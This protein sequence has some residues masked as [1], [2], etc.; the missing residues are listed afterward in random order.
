MPMS[1]PVHRA[2]GMRTA[3]QRRKE[4]DAKRGTV[5][6]R[7][8]GNQW[9]EASKAYR[10]LHPQCECTE[11]LKLP[12]IRRPP[13]EVVDHRIPH[14]G[15]QRLFWDSSNWQAMAKVCHDRKTAREDGAFGRDRS[16]A[17][18]PSRSRIGE[19]AGESVGAFPA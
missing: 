2:V 18:S 8:Y 15:D 3:Q 16:P 13:S 19:G 5:A 1:A 17:P 12:V 7:G 6:A 14:R 11:C 9:T 4:S 10:A